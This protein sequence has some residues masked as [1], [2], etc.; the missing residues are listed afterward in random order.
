[1]V[2][3][4]RPAALA[5]LDRR[6]IPVLAGRLRAAVT[7]S[8]AAVGR[9]RDD[10]GRQWTVV[11][12]ARKGRQVRSLRPV[13]GAGSQRVLGL[14]ALVLLVAAVALLVLGG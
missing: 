3:F 14:L 7:R 10:V 12:D 13:L 5:D 2:A 4:P 8:E 6:Y 11:R 9:L 1:M